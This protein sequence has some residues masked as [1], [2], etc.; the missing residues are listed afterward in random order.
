M[1]LGGV[2]AYAPSHRRCRL[3]QTYSSLTC[4]R[5]RFSL[6]TSLLT[7]LRQT[8]FFFLLFGYLTV[9]TSPLVYRRKGQILNHQHELNAVQRSL[10]TS[11][12][13]QLNAAPVSNQPSLFFGSFI[14]S[15]FICRTCC[16]LWLL[17][18]LFYFYHHSDDSKAVPLPFLFFRFL[19]PTFSSS[20]FFLLIPV[21]APFTFSAFPSP[22]R[23]IRLRW[24]PVVQPSSSSHTLAQGQ[25]RTSVSTSSDLF[26]LPSQRPI[27][28]WINSAGRAKKHH[29]GAHSWHLETLTDKHNNW[30]KN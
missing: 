8:V 10:I 15:F 20:L 21:T 4:V 1:W 5:K 23:C 26:S 14:T 19:P 2:P 9:Q 16:I 17:K 3:R 25:V 11:E 18:R 13:S 28:C 27:F 30:N 7:S 29:V 6:L 24:H 12:F 22:A